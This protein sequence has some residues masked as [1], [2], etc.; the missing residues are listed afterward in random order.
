MRTSQPLSQLD[1]CITAGVWGLSIVDSSTLYSG[2]VYGFDV[3]LAQ[4][5]KRIFVWDL[6]DVVKGRRRIDKEQSFLTEFLQGYNQ[7][8][9]ENSYNLS[10]LEVLIYLLSLVQFVYVVH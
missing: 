6:L 3:V 9:Q 10:F 5:P 2:T 1:G 8:I 4:D 7:S